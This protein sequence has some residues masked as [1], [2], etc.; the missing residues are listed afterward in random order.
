MNI[1]Q[2]SVCI[3][4]FSGIA[5]YSLYTRIVV[6]PLVQKTK[7]YVVCT[8]TI[9]GDTIRQIAQDKIDLEILMGPGVD[10]H[11]YK[12]VENDLIKIAQADLIVYHGLHLEARMADLFAHLNHVKPTLSATKDIPNNLLMSVNDNHTVFDPHVW[13]DPMIWIYV[14]K[15]ITQKL[16][17]LIPEHAAS[18]QHHQNMYIDNMVNMYEMTFAQIQK[19]PANKRFLITSHDAFSYFARAYDCNVVSLQGINT[20]T[21]AGVQDVQKIVTV[22]LQHQ[23]PTIFVES[24]VPPRNMMAIQE[25]VAAQHHHVTIGEELFS[26]SLGT[27][28]T[29]EGTY[30][31]MMCYN[32]SAITKGLSTSS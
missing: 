19:I 4:I 25:R 32:C 29:P 6:Q 31:G 15:T 12:P 16:S 5:L 21:Q 28:D 24:S 11:V 7:P 1:R 14:V 8:T 20:A 23:I 9:L 22:I 17:E 26:D 2:I 13:F 3:A 18:F 30:L 27:L 10:P